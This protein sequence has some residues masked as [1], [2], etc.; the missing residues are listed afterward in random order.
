MNNRGTSFACLHV[1]FLW[2]DSRKHNYKEEN[3]WVLPCIA[4]NVSTVYTPT[5]QREP[6]FL[7]PCL[8][9]SHLF[10][11]AVL[12]NEKCHKLL[13]VSHDLYICFLATYSS[14]IY[15]LSVCF[16]NLS[17]KVFIFIVLITICFKILLSLTFKVGRELTAENYC[18]LSTL[19]VAGLPLRLCNPEQFT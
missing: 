2:A 17:I 7:H 14:S 12:K 10:I 6:T 13:P 8:L 18:R 3:C 9:S 19:K 15:C 1:Y 11:H 5:T 4:R 16:S